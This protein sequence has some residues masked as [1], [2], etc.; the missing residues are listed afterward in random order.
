M[1]KYK[2]ILDKDTFLWLK[3]NEGIIYQSKNFQS[4]IFS[5]SDKLLKICSHLLEIDNLYAIKV[6]ENDLD[7]EDVRTFFDK[8]VSIGA[9]RL[10]QDTGA[11]KGAVSLLP[12]LTIEEGVNYHVNSHKRVIDSGIGHYV[13]EIT[14]YINGS[15]HG[16]D[17]YYRQVIFPMESELILESEKIVRFIKNNRNPYLFNI[18]I[19]GN[20]FAYPEYCDLLDNIMTFKFPVTICISSGDFL[21]NKD[22]LKRTEWHKKV[23]FHILIEKKTDIG[24]VVKSLTE[25]DTPISNTV[26]VFSEQDCFDIEHILE[27]LN[28]DIVPVYN[29]ENLDFFKSSVFVNQEDILA[30]TLT[31]REIFMRQVVNTHHFGK[32]TVLPDGV[33]YAD[34]NKE[35]LGMI[36]DSVYSIVY[37]EI[38]EGESWFRIRDQ[39]PCSDCI[40]QWLCPSP[41]NYETA[42][43]RQNLCHVVS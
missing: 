40:Y 25:V 32:L 43:G 39:K 37:K 22:L 36:D 17:K 15:K 10:I 3:T 30:S 28:S 1:K 34:V 21:D 5:L 33:V 2:L 24:L 42:I 12:V 23:S 6:T 16:N 27:T 9:G 38:T 20:I 13:H 4:F 18:N 35:P 8:I 31:K 11:E 41:S 14:F 19:V 29:G 26:F 7:N